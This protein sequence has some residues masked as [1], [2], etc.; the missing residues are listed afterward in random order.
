MIGLVLA[1]GV[2]TLAQVLLVGVAPIDPVSFGGTALLFFLVLA[3]AAWTPASRAAATAAGD[4]SQGGVTSK[5]LIIGALIRL[6][7]RIAEFGGDLQA[8]DRGH[9]ERRLPWREADRLESGAP[10]R[11][12]DSLAA[13]GFANGQRFTTSQKL[14]AVIRSVRSRICTT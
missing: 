4:G 3:L 12:A 1:A 8:G 13:S 2:G 5:I 11:T 6:L 7:R 9:G 10:L 14:A